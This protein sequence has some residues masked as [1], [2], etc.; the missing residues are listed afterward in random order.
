MKTEKGKKRIFSRDKNN[1]YIKENNDTFSKEISPKTP[2][3][4][5]AIKKSIEQEDPF[6]FVTKRCIVGRLDGNSD[7]LSYETYLKNILPITSL[8][9][10]DSSWHT[11]KRGR[12]LKLRKINDDNDEY[13]EALRKDKEKKD[14]LIDYII[15]DFDGD[16]RDGH[17]KAL[18][19]NFQG[20]KTI[21]NDDNLREWILN[22]LRHEKHK[23]TYFQKQSK[24]HLILDHLV[25]IYKQEIKKN[26]R[27]P[28]FTKF[29]Y[30]AFQLMKKG[31]LSKVTYDD[32]CRL[33]IKPEKANDPADASRD[34]IRAAQRL[35]ALCPE[36]LHCEPI[37]ETLIDL[38]RKYKSTPAA[39]EKKQS[40]ESL[41]LIKD[42][43]IRFIGKTSKIPYCERDIKKLIKLLLRQGKSLTE[44][45]EKVSEDL[46][47]SLSHI[48]HNY[49][50]TRL[51]KR[52]DSH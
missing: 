45:Q 23:L 50:M 20:K 6:A 31:T 46:G 51:K 12:R 37:I 25:A 26:S 39:M 8:D 16:F 21:W 47:I 10:S 3:N 52:F 14:D 43:W 33:L 48:K 34:R 32:L 1:E 49:T 29:I 22:N 42:E 38:I 13:L 5:T 41:R 30:D 11:Y 24:T 35:V 9:D 19:K 4:S 40:G 7:D 15:E 28:A 17:G 2:G 36:I 18:P 27:S 44:S